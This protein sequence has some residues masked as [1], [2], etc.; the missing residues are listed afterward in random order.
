MTGCSLLYDFPYW[1]GSRSASVRSEA[2]LASMRTVCKGTAY[3]ERV[4]GYRLV[5]EYGE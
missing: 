5:G 3:R 4:E 1:N 2:E